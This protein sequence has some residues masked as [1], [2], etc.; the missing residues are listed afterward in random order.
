MADVSIIVTTYNV[1][2][3]IKQCLD[4]LIAQTLSDIEIIVVDDGSSDDTCMIIEDC[5][6]ADARIKPILL[7]ENSIGGVATPANVGLDAATCDYVG[8][9]DGDDFCE[10]QMFEKL[11]KAAK[12]GDHDL[13]MC[14]YKLL[15][16]STGDYSDPAE[17][18][19]WAEI[20]K[21]QYALNLQTRK[22]FLKFIAVPWRKLYKRSLLE[23]HKI[24]F[25][26]GDY[27]YEDNPFHWFALTK[28]GSIA[29]VPEVLCYHR[30]AR[31]GQTMATADEKLFRIFA[32]HDTIRAWLVEHGIEGD[33]RATLLA[34]V[35]SQLEWISARTPKDLR[36]ALFDALAPIFANYSA[37]D[38]AAALSE[39]KKGQRAKKICDA[40]IAQDFGQFNSML[41]GAKRQENLLLHG[42]YHLRHSG[43]RQTATMT[44][45]FV[46][47]KVM[48]VG[49]RVRRRL[50]GRKPTDVS[51][52]DLMFSMMVLQRH[53]TSI[54]A[55]LKALEET[56]KDK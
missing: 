12:A 54:E 15:D 26:V 4:S 23:E 36:R 46:A 7:K 30:V 3:Y 16:E 43:L 10:P 18:A 48:N 31:A 55:R 6:K 22:Q 33:F 13:S 29:V 8:F 1:A 27:F 32:H 25:P 52:E 9:A 47:E 49:G 44:G 51:N 40:L 35:V 34:W 28:A 53:L 56:K 14:K 20:T 2:D 17:V 39:G 21:T 11:Y 50:S 38:V 45:R 42:F 24:R 19:R 5:A 37:E 41:D